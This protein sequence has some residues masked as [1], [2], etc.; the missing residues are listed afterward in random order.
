MARGLTEFNIQQSLNTTAFGDWNYEEL[1]L[2]DGSA[3]TDDTC[4]LTDDPT[5]AHDSN[6]DI[7]AGMA[8]TGSGIPANS[9]VGIKSSNTAFE[10]Y[11]DGS[12]VSTT[13]GAASD[14]ELTFTGGEDSE[15]ATYISSIN[16][17][18]KIVLYEVPGSAS[19][20]LQD[21]D[22][23]TLTINGKT[24]SVKKMIIDADDLPF[25]LSSIMITS[26]IVT[27]NQANLTDKVALLS[28]H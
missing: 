8:V 10:L 4:D 21:I 14:V 3:I 18:K 13:G 17:A 25:T 22:T 5:I 2:N 19:S 9:Y 26:L 1:D 24:S 6:A 23:L 28:F 7:K 12:E 27:I 16:P 20:Y 15:T 11:K